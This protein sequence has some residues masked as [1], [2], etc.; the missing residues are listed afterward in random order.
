MVRTANVGHMSLE[1]LYIKRVRL[2][3]CLWKSIP[4]RVKAVLWALWVNPI[5]AQRVTSLWAN[6]NL[7]D[8]SLASG[9]LIVPYVYAG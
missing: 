6:I 4:G 7:I 5:L 9:R 8:V 3:N 1:Y 2:R